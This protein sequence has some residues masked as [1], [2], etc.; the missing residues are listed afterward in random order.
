VIETGTRRGG[1]ALAYASVLDQLHKGQ[2]HKGKVLS[3]DAQSSPGRPA[4][5]R[6]AY[7]T[8]SSTDETVLAK[9]RSQIKPGDRVM[10][11]LNSSH[12]Q[13]HVAKELKLYAPM[14]AAGSYLVVHDTQLNGHPL[15][16]SP[17]LRVGV[18]GPYEAVEDFLH[19]NS[20][21]IADKSRERFGVTD[22]PMGWLKR[23]R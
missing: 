23:V 2:L 15:D 1:S 21:F 19:A 6:I 11:V 13:T 5:E 22:N 14:V 17:R 4:H 8:G 10:V 16:V 9:V 18:E 3:I 7:V 12:E 20:N